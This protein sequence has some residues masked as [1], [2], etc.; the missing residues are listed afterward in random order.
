[1]LELYILATIICLFLSLGLNVVISQN[2]V[3]SILY[4]VLFF[5]TGS[6]FLALFGFDY[7]SLIFILVYVGAIAVLFLFVVMILD[8]KIINGSG[9]D[10][11]FL[12]YLCLLLFL[13]PGAYQICLFLLTLHKSGLDLCFQLPLAGMSRSYDEVFLGSAG[14]IV[15]LLGDSKLFVLF[16]EVFAGSFL[17]LENHLIDC[18]LYLSSAIGFY[19]FFILLRVFF[20]AHGFVAPEPQVL[21]FESS[22]LFKVDYDSSVKNFQVLYTDFTSLFVI[23][24]GV[25]LVAMTSCIS[26]ALPSRQQIS[27]RHVGRKF[28]DS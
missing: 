8:I 20:C 16:N 11:R 9:F 6:S 10:G 17:L 19:D 26:L 1:M 13:L 28:Q 18:D 25:L 24:G 27:P 15:I 5:I 23:C 2:P 22:E 21:L 7:L 4:L 14:D 3:Y 12:V